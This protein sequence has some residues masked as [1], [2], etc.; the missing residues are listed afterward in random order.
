MPQ[1]SLFVLSV[2]MV[3]IFNMMNSNL[4]NL[5]GKKCYAIYTVIN[6]CE[7]QVNIGVN[8]ILGKKDVSS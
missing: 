6:F 5:H 8:T 7:Y 1:K 4:E 2:L 3:R